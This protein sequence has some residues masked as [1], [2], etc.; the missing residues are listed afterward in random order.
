MS[1]PLPIYAVILNICQYDCAEGRVR[2][3]YRDEI[4]CKHIPLALCIKC[5]RN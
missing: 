3:K 5:F 2:K 4:V 1:V